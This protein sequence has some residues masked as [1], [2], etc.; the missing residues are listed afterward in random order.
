MGYGIACPGYEGDFSCFMKRKHTGSST[1]SYG[2][3]EYERFCKKDYE[4]GGFGDCPHFY[5]YTH[6]YIVT[7]VLRKL[8][9][10]M[11]APE[12]EISRAFRTKIENKQIC[13]ASLD[14]YDVVGPILARI[15]ENDDELAKD[16]YINTIIPVTRLIYQGEDKK[17]LSMY[18]TMVRNLLTKIKEPLQK[19]INTINP[20][21]VINQT[22]LTK[23]PN[24]KQETVK[25][26][27]RKQR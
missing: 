22:N 11:K 12:F 5:W 23:M 19:S 3:T 1:I 18:M 26:L 21:S 8:F 13:K 16:I 4:K 20:Y 27:K 25:I 6:Q 14:K 17:A 7:A 24:S 9:P 10:N 2:S 15:V